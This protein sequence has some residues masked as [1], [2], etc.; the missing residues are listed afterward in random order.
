MTA[1]TWWTYSSLQTFRECPQRYKFQYVDRLGTSTKSAAM[2][3]GNR[4]HKAL[5][6]Y[7]LSGTPFGADNAVLAAW[8]PALDNLRSLKAVAEEMWEFDEGWWPLESGKT[9][10]H[11]SKLDAHARKKTTA[12]VVDYKSGRRYP[13]HRK[14]KE[15]YAIDTF[16]KF[17]GITDLTMEFWYLDEGSGHGIDRTEISRDDIGRIAKRWRLAA[18][19]CLTA[20]KFEPYPGTA[21]KYCAFAKSKGGPCTKG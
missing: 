20:T 15:V 21:C 18:G 19:N 14:Q 2:E 3:R 16:A 6:D 7:L 13:E 1:Y 12:L 5:E 8:K 9:L 17:D 4:L 10:W 11:R